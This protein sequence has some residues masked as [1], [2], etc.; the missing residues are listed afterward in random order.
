MTFAWSH[1]LPSAQGANAPLSGLITLL[2]AL[3][4]LRWSADAAGVDMGVRYSRRI[5]LMAL[6]GEP[7]GYMGSRRLLWEAASGSNA[8][9]GLD[10]ALIE[11]VRLLL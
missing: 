10:V 11:Q 9:A 1:E 2:A 3:K 4:L 5:V 8:T 6:A 7:W